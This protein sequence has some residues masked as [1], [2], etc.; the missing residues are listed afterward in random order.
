M[1]LHQFDL[2]EKC[3]FEDRCAN[4]F[5]KRTTPQADIPIDWEPFVKAAVATGRFGNREEVLI[6]ALQRLHDER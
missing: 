4:D 1:G 6:Q 2:T 3:Q 5:A